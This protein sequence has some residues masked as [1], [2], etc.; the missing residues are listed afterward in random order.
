MCGGEDL[1]TGPRGGFIPG[2]EPHRCPRCPNTCAFKGQ[3][4]A[5]VVEAQPVCEVDVDVWLRG[6]KVA[7]V[8][9]CVVWPPP[10]TSHRARKQNVCCANRSVGINEVVCG[11]RLGRLP[12]IINGRTDFEMSVVTQTDDHTI[13][14]HVSFRPTIPPN[15]HK[16]DTAT[17]L[18]VWSMLLIVSG[19]LINLYHIKSLLMSVVVT[20]ISKKQQ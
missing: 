2:V 3:N 9:V 10:N 6:S 11:A 7:R 12:L 18:V 15:K 13:C 19:I 4:S 1:W 14:Q 8:K 5:C 17:F 16:Q 20:F